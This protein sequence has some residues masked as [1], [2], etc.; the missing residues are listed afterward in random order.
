MLFENATKTLISSGS[1]ATP[2]F[3]AATLPCVLRAAWVCPLKVD[4]KTPLHN[5]VWWNGIKLQTQ[6]HHSGVKVKDFEC[7]EC[8]KVFPGKEKIWMKELKCT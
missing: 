4:L 3:T 2:R 5:A 1:A 8:C 6:T 7:C